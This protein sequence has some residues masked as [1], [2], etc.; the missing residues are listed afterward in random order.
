MKSCTDA[1][2][3]ILVNNFYAGHGG[4]V[5]SEHL[6]C[7]LGIHRLQLVLISPTLADATPQAIW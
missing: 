3:A 7:R 1:D 4:G 6:I 2:V 5:L